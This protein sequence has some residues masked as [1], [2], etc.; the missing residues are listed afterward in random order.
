M[1]PSKEYVTVASSYSNS[2]VTST[3]GN[4]TTTIVNISARNLGYSDLTENK[5]V[6]GANILR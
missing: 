4:E 3:R 6:D 2:K 1:S 5:L